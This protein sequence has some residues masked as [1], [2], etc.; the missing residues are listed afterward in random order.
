[1]VYKEENPKNGRDK[2]ISKIF[3]KVLEKSKNNAIL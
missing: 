1:M 2:K 3:G